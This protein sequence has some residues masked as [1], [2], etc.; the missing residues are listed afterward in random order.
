MD[1]IFEQIC[2]KKIYIYPI[3]TKKKMVTSLVIRKIQIIIKYNF[4]FTRMTKSKR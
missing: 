3:S 1:K 2:P 4:A